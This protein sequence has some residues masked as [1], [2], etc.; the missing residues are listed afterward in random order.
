LLELR[1]NVDFIWRFLLGV[2]ALP[3]F[4]VL[5]LRLRQGKRIR[6]KREKADQGEADNLSDRDVEDTSES[7]NS[8]NDVTEKSE[9]TDSGSVEMAP[10]SAEHSSPPSLLLSDSRDS[11]ESQEPDNELALV[12]NSYIESNME[13]AANNNETTRTL[14]QSQSPS[15]WESIT[16]EPNLCRKFAGTAGTWFLFDVLFYGNTLFGEFSTDV[17]V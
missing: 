5:F 1:Y 15:I 12:E 6:D 16:N 11:H 10:S 3:G 4:V 9:I 13:E 2:G 8:A 7:S 17:F 14:N